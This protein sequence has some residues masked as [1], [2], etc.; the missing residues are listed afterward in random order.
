MTK[1][2]MRTTEYRIK[3]AP[4]DG[5]IGCADKKDEDTSVNNS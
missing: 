5:D 3:N 2:E 1:T 4:D